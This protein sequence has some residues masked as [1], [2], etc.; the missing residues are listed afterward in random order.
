MKPVPEHCRA[1][2]VVAPGEPLEI[3]D[4]QVPTESEHG[5]LLVETALATICGSDI[6]IC[7]GDVGSSEVANVFAV[8][9]GHEMVGWVAKLG[10]GVTVDSVG[11]ELRCGDRSLL[12]GAPVR[13]ATRG[14][15]Q[16]GRHGHHPL[17]TVRDQHGVRRDEGVDRDQACPDVRLSS[18]SHGLGQSHP[19]ASAR[20]H[21]RRSGERPC[22]RPL[23]GSI[24]RGRVRVA[25]S[26]RTVRDSPS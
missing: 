20:N 13:A 3:H 7:E 22:V 26:I 5:S 21:L 14:P 23:D 25:P 17:P 10:P 2:V 18:D 8:I 19:P 11:Q 9:P 16:L 1:A 24:T 4:V 12:V 15:V 6:H